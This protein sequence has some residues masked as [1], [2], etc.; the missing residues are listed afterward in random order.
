MR[1]GVVVLLH[2]GYWAAYLLVLALVVAVLR[3]QVDPAGP[4]LSVRLTARLGALA[5]LPNVAAFYLSYLVLF[6][7]S[8]RGGGSP[9]CWRRGRR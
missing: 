8:S 1:R 9:R 6:P 7:A 4:L 3:L 5:V 2:V